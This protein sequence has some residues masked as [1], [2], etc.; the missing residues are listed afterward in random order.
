MTSPSYI[1]LEK[2]KRQSYPPPL[3][4]ASESQIPIFHSGAPYTGQNVLMDTPDP[5]HNSGHHWRRV[6]QPKSRGP[7]CLSSVWDLLKALLLPMLAIAYLTFC[8]VVHYRVIP[9]KA[10]GLVNVSPQNIGGQFF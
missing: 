3:T 4:S 8:Y 6:P 2:H 1:P 5:K 7:S 10:H 9:V